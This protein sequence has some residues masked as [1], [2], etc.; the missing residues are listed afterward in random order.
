MNVNCHQ[1]QFYLVLLIL[2]FKK[3]YLEGAYYF[4]ST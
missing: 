4:N 1:F 3:N 2:K